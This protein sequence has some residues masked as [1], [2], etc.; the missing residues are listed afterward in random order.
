[1]CIRDRHCSMYVRCDSDRVPSWRGWNEERNRTSRKEPPAYPEHSPVYEYGARRR[2][3]PPCTRDASD[4]RTKYPWDQW[5]CCF[6]QLEKHLDSFAKGSAKLSVQWQPST[7]WLRST[8]WL[9]CI[10][11][12]PRLRI[13]L[14]FLRRQSLGRSLIFGAKDQIFWND[15]WS[16]SAKITFIDLQKWSQ[17]K[18]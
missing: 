10:Q 3:R 7:Q 5:L 6:W 15:L 1:M 12:L 16:L 9:P 4:T 14:L 18:R 17:S 13:L 8:Q 2:P 11:I